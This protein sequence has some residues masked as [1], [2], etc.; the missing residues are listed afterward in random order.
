MPAS[1]ALNIAPQALKGWLGSKCDTSVALHHQGA[2]ADGGLIPSVVS[3]VHCSK[4]DSICFQLFSF[5]LLILLLVVV[6]VIVELVLFAES[7]NINN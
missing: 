3:R 6:V 1:Q 4:K 5:Q 7:Q 2:I